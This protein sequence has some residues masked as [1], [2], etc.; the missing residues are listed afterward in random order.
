MLQKWDLNSYWVF[1]IHKE[2]WYLSATKY[3]E[4]MPQVKWMEISNNVIQKK[5]C[6]IC[7]N[8]KSWKDGLM[9]CM[10]VCFYFHVV[11]FTK[12]GLLCCSKLYIRGMFLCLGWTTKK[13]QFWYKGIPRKKPL[14]H[15]CLSVFCIL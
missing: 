3:N 15:L 1:L 8:L 7:K 6:L 4:K 14:L 5:L 12:A 11:Q 9:T 2:F 10:Y 13:N